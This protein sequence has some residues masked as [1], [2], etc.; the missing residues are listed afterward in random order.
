MK[1]PENIQLSP[2]LENMR[3]QVGDQRFAQ[4]LEQAQRQMEAGSP[5]PETVVTPTPDSKTSAQVTSAVHPIGFESAISIKQGGA[6][7]DSEFEQL[8]SALLVKGEGRLMDSQGKDTGAADAV[9]IITGLGDK[10][11]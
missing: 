5:K 2:E 4:V 10:E 1:Q 8:V 9:N 6:G 3:K 11:P 7:N